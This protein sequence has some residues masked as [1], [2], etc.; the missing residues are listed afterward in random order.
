MQKICALI[1][2]V[3]LL[4]FQVGYGQNAGLKGKVLDE[5]GEPLV[6]AT[7]LVEG[8]GKGMY[9]D[10]DGNYSLTGLPAGEQV[11][12]IS[13]LGYEESRELVTLIEGES[14]NL[15]TGMR[16]EGKSIDDVIIVGYGVERKREMTGS[17][18]KVGTKE[19]NEIPA[20]S[21]EA[22]LQ[23]KA[24]G[25][26]VIQG[27]GIAGSGAMVRVRG[28]GSISAGGD[29]LYVVDGIPITQDP[30]INGDR[31]GQN[32]NPLASINPQ[33]I[34]S[35][36][37]L[38]DAAAAAI[39]GSRGAN[40]VVLVTTKRGRRGK[41]TFNLNVRAGVSQ[42]T[43][44]I[45]FLDADEWLQLY[46]EA[47]ENDGNTGV[48]DILPG[49]YTYQQ[50]LD[51]GNTNW[52]DHTVGTGFKQE[53]NLSV[54]QGGKKLSTFASLGFM[55][56]E[57]YLL[58]NSYRRYS[59][60]LNLDYKILPNLL[61][62]V[63]STGSWGRNNRVSQAWEGSLGTAQSTA[64][65]YYGVDEPNSSFGY[66]GN[67]ITRRSSIDWRTIEARTINSARFEYKPL[68]NLTLTANGSLDYMDIGDNYL[69]DT[70]WTNFFSVA[71]DYHTK[72]LNWNVNGFAQYDFSMLPENHKLS[73]MAGS[74]AQRSERNSTYMEVTDVNNHLYLDW[75]GTDNSDTVETTNPRDAFSFASVFGRLNYSLSDKY[76]FKASIR[77]DA[78]SKFGSN[79]R[80]GVFPALG[81]GYIISE[82]DFWK[83]KLGNTVNF[84]KLKA[85]YGVTGNA[86]IPS[87]LRF[88]TFS[89]RDNNI[90]Y[91]GDS[92]IF[93]IR[94]ENPDLSWET[95]TTID[96]GFEFGILNDRINGE[97]A[98]YNKESRDVLLQTA[99]QPS[100]GF[101][102]FWQNIGHIRNRGIEFSVTSYNLVGKFK[103]R[104]VLNIAR[105]RNLVV[106]V[107]TTP[108]D[109]LAGSGDTRVVV[110]EPVGVNY[111]VRFSHID[112]ENG[113]PVYLDADGNETFDWSTDHRVVVGNVQPDFQGGI[114]NIF[115]FQNFDL[116]VFWTFTVGGK[117]YDDAA[118]RYNGVMVD[119]NMRRDI[120]DRWTG[121]GD[122]DATYPVLTTDPATYGLDNYWNYN[123]T[124]WLYDAS[125]ARLKNLSLGYNV[126]M[127][128]EKKNLVK[129]LRVYA[130]ATNLLTFTPYPG[131]DPEIVRDH[132]GPQGRNISPNVTY[133]TP[134]QE[135]VYT[136]GVDLDF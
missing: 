87:F 18:S 124:Q 130:S 20:T 133:L 67:P 115:E 81:A 109:A 13:Y 30:F 122:T 134:P 114:R 5:T 97:F 77:V 123:T 43:N 72:V 128:P 44:L 105:N 112:S 132:N 127:N 25:V 9:S 108:P 113:R 28:A 75:E 7:I 48:P 136:V 86:D 42:P 24:A 119:W 96:A 21:L 39:Y 100:A 36:E 102:T 35:I 104:T 3:L 82:E 88:G 95:T 76:V 55:D 62:G 120:I 84:F 16:L 116:N 8:T 91:N 4:S 15:S 99:T 22:T 90:Q 121:P 46:Q 56:N 34:E 26:Q 11:V 131:S 38:K 85:S 64:L 49:G 32:N 58:G 23:G 37:I 117:I 63:S 61:V 80:Y 107:G 111:L 19:I 110:G 106:D 41:P 14:I 57:S 50:A 101:N 69:E 52:Y 89:G 45:E 51:N 98:V 92:I 73:L 66:P 12:V 17:V 70:V 54:R 59:G 135:R 60:R 10:A 74:E 31:G 94:L 118:K 40:G 27:S 83:N 68:E 2:L 93:P 125:Y 1:P 71:K 79:N 33:D 65:P 53:Y 126:P 6:G 78:S 29:P 47:W 103:W 129:R